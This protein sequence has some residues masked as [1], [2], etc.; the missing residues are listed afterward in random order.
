MAE[1]LKNIFYTKPYFNELCGDIKKIYPSFDDKKFLNLI[2][3]QNWETLELKQRMHH[4]AVSIN[5]LFPEEYNVALNLLLDIAVKERSKHPHFFEDLFFADFVETYGI[6]YPDLSI[7]ALGVFTKYSSGEFAIRP[8]IK[9]Y[10]ELVMKQMLEW[11]LSDNQHVRR[12]SSEGCR[13][14]LPWAMGLPAFKKD[15]SPIIP[16]L[17]NLKADESEYVRKSVANNLNDIS[18][19]N[20]ALVM[21]LC[22]SWFGKNKHTDWIIKRALRTLL[23]QGNVDAMKLFGFNGK[24]NFEIDNFKLAKNKIKIG[25][26]LEFSFSI[27]NKSRKKNKLRIEYL[28]HYAKTNGKVS[29]KIFQLSEKEFNAGEALSVNKKQSFKDMTTRKHHPGKHKIGIVINGK[30]IITK[31]FEVMK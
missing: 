15:P 3:D 18:K 19:D 26:T 12:L 23:K 6:N 10:P 2:Y 29:K 20:P 28:I 31:D 27:K 16:I 25:A 1:L 7:P 8:F 4:T 14:R 17:E 11:S 9:K 22:K 5:K 21:K 30:E 24:N 13:P